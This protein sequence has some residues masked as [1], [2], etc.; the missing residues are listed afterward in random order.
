MLNSSKQFNIYKGSY[1]SNN[2]LPN[3][4]SYRRNSSFT[5][6]EVV[7]FH[8][9]DI[10]AERYKLKN[11]MTKIPQKYN[12]D[13]IIYDKEAWE[14]H[15]EYM[16]NRCGCESRYVEKMKEDFNKLVERKIGNYTEYRDHTEYYKDVDGNI[17]SIF[18]KWL[19][20][21][22]DKIKHI[23]ESGYTLIEPI[24][25]LDQKTFIKVIQTK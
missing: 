16:K 2:Y 22:D 7:I 17:L 6:E 12:R 19:S 8:N 14:H 11:I 23:L 25:A 1:W 20:Y 15:K 10:I 3:G 13:I 21:E 24:Y 18:S 4:C 9:R 5:P